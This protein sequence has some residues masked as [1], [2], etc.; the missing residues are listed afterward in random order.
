M[1]YERRDTD[2]MLAQ[3][4][5]LTSTDLN[6]SFYITNLCLF[7]SLNWII[8][9]VGIYSVP[10]FLR[11]C[12]SYCKN[13]TN[14]ITTKELILNEF[15][16][17]TVMVCASINILC[18]VVYFLSDYIS[19]FFDLYFGIFILPLM[20]ITFI[21]EVTFIWISVKDFKISDSV[22]L[23][24]NRYVMRA[25]HTLAICHIL[26]FLHR[27]GCNLL[28]AIFFIALAPAQTLAAISSIYFIIFCM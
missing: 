26:W 11:Q 6:L 16:W 2:K 15:Y 27:I 10:R 22:C 24:S 3:Y 7:Y 14:V 21:I 13:S 20:F 19:T 17:D 5:K 18:T 25:I 28:V 23:F 9:I 12:V 4:E 8:T 1:V